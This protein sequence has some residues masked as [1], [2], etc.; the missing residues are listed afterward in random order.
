MKKSVLPAPLTFEEIFAAELKE[1]A[2]K[3]AGAGQPEPTAKPGIPA[4]CCSPG[5][6][7]CERR[8]TV[9]D[10]DEDGDGATS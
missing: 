6:G 9:V 7:F 2:A 1:I 5:S 8:A 10:A 3:R 4:N